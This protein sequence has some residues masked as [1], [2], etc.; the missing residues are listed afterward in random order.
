MLKILLVTNLYPNQFELT[1]GIFTEQ[2][3]R[4]LRVKNEVEV[5]APVPWVPPFINDIVKKQLEEIGK[6]KHLKK[7][8]L[9]NVYFSPPHLS[10]VLLGL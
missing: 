10:P 6:I 8:Y 9:T 1:R 7:Q 2:I 4:C 3:V 5:V